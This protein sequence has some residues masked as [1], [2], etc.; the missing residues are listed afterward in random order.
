MQPGRPY[1]LCGHRRIKVTVLETPPELRR[2][3]RVRVRFESGVKAGEVADVPS[4]RIASPWGESKTRQQKT[5]RQS[6]ALI[7]RTPEVGDEVAWSGDRRTWRW[8]VD[9]LNEK[10]GQATISTVM[11]EQKTTQTVPLDQLEVRLEEPPSAPPFEAVLNELS[12]DGQ[13]EDSGDST[14][15]LDAEAWVA[16]N[17]RPEKPRRAVDTMLDGI[18]FSPGCLSAYRRRYAL[19]LSGT[20]LSEHLIDTIRGKGSVIFPESPETREYARIRVPGRFDVVLNSSP[21]G[22]EPVIVQR[23]AYLSPSRHGHK[24]RRRKPRRSGRE[25]RRAA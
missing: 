24:K 10:E 3:A 13:P 1:V 2:K 4:R 22:D 5:P 6:L 7:E 8:T 20:A 18:L 12:R 21:T 14:A 19:H 16:E 25:Q 23:L 17:L 15:A 11:V 9:E